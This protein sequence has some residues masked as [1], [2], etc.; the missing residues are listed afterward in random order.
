MKIYD[1]CFPCFE[2]Q[3]ETAL[4][5]I[6]KSLYGEIRKEVNELLKN[7]DVSLSPPEIAGEMFKIINKLTNGF[8]SYFKIKEKSNQYILVVVQ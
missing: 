6:D 5:D 1:R 7:I 2:K 4:K 3:L 8:D